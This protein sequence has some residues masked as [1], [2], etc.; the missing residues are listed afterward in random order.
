LGSLGAR[1]PVV[2]QDVRRVWIVLTILLAVM[3]TLVWVATRPNWQDEPIVAVAGAT[4]STSLQVTVR[5]KQCG[6]RPRV[7]VSQSSTDFIGLRAD[8]DEQGD[9]DDI[10]VDTPVD[11]ELEE[12]LG[13]RSL[14]IE[15]ADPAL[16]C[17]VE[18][19]SEDICI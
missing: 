4:D 12:A 14:H 5:H 16:D 15:R 19:A 11:V 17:S 9:C 3:A 10:A 2:D 1:L 6:G 18:G 7:H 8:Y 13:A